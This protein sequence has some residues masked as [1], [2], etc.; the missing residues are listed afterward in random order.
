M[1]AKGCFYVGA[2]LCRLH[3]SSVFGA[4][5]VF[6]VDANHVFPQ[7]VLAA[8]T[9][10]GDVVS[11]GGSKACAGYEVALPLCSMAVVTQLGARSAP[12]LL[13]QKT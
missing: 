5:A 12:R 6:D 7:C 9:L 10:V 4:R 3:V 8:T 11:V 1:V 13:E 2:S